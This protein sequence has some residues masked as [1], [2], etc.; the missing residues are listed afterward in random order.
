MQTLL[1]IIIPSYNRTELLTSSVNKLVD[2]FKILNFN[3]YEIIVV[4]NGNVQN[5]SF[6]FGENVK[7][8]NFEEQMNPGIARNFG[9][10]NSKSEWVWFIDDDDELYF[11]NVSKVIELIN[12]SKADIIAHSLK[13]KY[14][15][16][17]VKNELLNNILLFK[18]KQE[19]FNYIFKRNIVDNNQIKFS[20]GVHEDIRYAVE[21]VLHANKIE[22]LDSKIYN[23]ITREDSIT[24]KLNTNRIAGYL[25]AISEVL[26]I[27]NPIVSELKTEIV[28]QSLGTI[29]YLIN[30][31]EINEKAEFINYLEEHFPKEFRNLIKKKYTEKS[32]NFKYASSLF[33]YKKDTQKFIDDLDYCFKT[34]LSCK[35][36]K[37]SIFFGPGEII[38]CC[39][40]FF[41]KGKMKGDIVL[42]NNSSDITLNKILD[43]KKEVEDLINMESYE[44]CEGCPYLQRFEKNN[45]EK[46]NYISLENFTYCNMKCT[47]CA[48]KY[49]G[50]REPAYDTDS[51]ISDLLNGEYLG[52]DVHIVWGG[53][54]PTLKPKFDVITNNLL[55]SDKVS[56]IRVLTNS[57]RFSK[58]LDEIASNKKIRIVTSIDAGSQTKFKEIRGKGEIVKVLENLKIYNEKI[59]APENLT[60]KYILT[61]DNYYSEELE[62]FVRVIKEFGFENNFI[63]ISCN[64]KLETPTEEMTYAIYELAGRLLNSGFQFVYFDDLIRDRLDLS[65]EMAENIIEFLKSKN[66]FHKNILSH[67]SNQNIILW[68]DGY[69]SKWIKNK[70]LFGKTGNIFKVV[71]NADELSD[72]E[73]NDN[74]IICPAAIQSLPEIYKEIKKS[75][76][77]D[78]TIFAIFI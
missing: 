22:I 15:N 32:S 5:I 43:R 74:I 8:Y 10:D 18:E 19:L 31:S 70:T 66:L 24:K 1:S 7:V 53:G 13:L 2:N 20:N 39:K 40:R 21:L 55:N 78:K 72:T 77:I 30:K 42:M 9:M 50:G 49:Y 26:N 29:L 67:H 59:D 54:E 61:E 3:D 6:S 16:T 56:K 62:E 52:N 4:N 36:L 51:I 76:L 34:Y 38:G 44:E 27:D 37:N 57:L 65:K 63:Q 25:N 46:V 60:I 58:S 33:L 14:K 17:E 41:Y 12:S 45:D 75:N 28:L 64:F 48:P 69:Q 35:D 23:K 47:Y 68:G 71:T 73:L 11:E